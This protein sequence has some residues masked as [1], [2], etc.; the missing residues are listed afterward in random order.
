MKLPGEAQ[1][2]FRPLLLGCSEKITK[3]NMSV[4]WS[5]KFSMLNKPVKYLLV[6]YLLVLASFKLDQEIFAHFLFPL[7]YKLCLCHEFQKDS[8]S[9]CRVA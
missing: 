8:P 3:K 4:I 5:I 9:F 6:K 7:S 2:N 1:E